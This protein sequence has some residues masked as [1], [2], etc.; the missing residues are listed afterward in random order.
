VSKTSIDLNHESRTRRRTLAGG[1]SERSEAKLDD[2]CGFSAGTGKVIM[3]PNTLS[4]NSLKRFARAL[5]H[6][7]IRT[8]IDGR[9]CAVCAKILSGASR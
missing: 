5:R 4:E 9:T 1:K 8:L 7:A 2:S 6:H 3:T